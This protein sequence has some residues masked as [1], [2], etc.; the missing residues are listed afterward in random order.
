MSSPLAPN[1][2]PVSLPFG[3][4]R[5]R[6]IVS[7]REDASCSYTVSADPDWIA[8]DPLTVAGNGAVTVQVEY[9][10][11]RARNGTVSIGSTEV[12]VTQDPEPVLPAAGTC[13]YGVFPD[14]VNVSNER[15]QGAIS[16][17]WEYV[18]DEQFP[19]PVPD[20]DEG[21]GCVSWAA[22]APASWISV[23]K[24][25]ANTAK[26]TIDPNPTTPGR[27]S[28]IRIG[29]RGIDRRV[30]V[31]QGLSP[32]T[33][34]RERLLLDWTIRREKGSVCDGWK[35]LHD[36]EK[37]VFI[38]NTH[39][40]YITDMLSH[41]TK[42]YSI[43]GKGPGCGGTGL[44]RMYMSM[45][46]TLNSTLV[47]YA[48]PDWRRTRDFSCLVSFP[49]S[50]HLLT[51]CP[52]EPFWYQTETHTDSPTGQIQFFEG[53]LVTVERE[54]T[55][56]TDLSLNFVRDCDPI[57]DTWTV[58]VKPDEICHGYCHGEYPVGACT[59]SVTY[60]E[61][62][63]G[64]PPAS[65]TYM[66]PHDEGYTIDNDGYSFEMDQDYSSVIPLHVHSS[67]PS[68]HDMK[69]TY[70]TEYGDPGWDWN[71]PNCPISALDS[72]ESTLQEGRSAVRAVYVE[73]LRARIGA[74]RER[75]GLRP[76][77]WTDPTLT[78][79]VTGVKAVHLVELRTALNEAH[80]EAGQVSPTYT[81]DPVVAG[82]TAIRAVHLTELRQ[83]VI[84]VEEVQP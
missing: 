12:M 76:F 82:T 32:L 9:N 6:T 59:G 74:L 41:V 35:S 56:G 42:L 73:E 64:G 65:Y 68:C 46:E 38:W 11:D 66:L 79:G 27:E 77:V 55:S 23:S 51:A 2:Q 16:V 21:S 61:R 72:I 34:E 53:G 71:P 37:E 83:A 63:I 45:S 7:V 28:W 20:P 5:N 67:A 54:H 50:E 31:Q 13:R 4:D 49:L 81:D 60:T 14:S 30:P 75:F 78:H 29:D 15:G 26:Y 52:H 18:P 1:T 44:N 24:F 57:D 22:T 84:A 58:Y 69:I 19:D 43:T 48:H 39:R 36:T 33:S 17:S 70:S 80:Q 47:A 62:R 25:D 10:S 8:V 3:Y 40:L